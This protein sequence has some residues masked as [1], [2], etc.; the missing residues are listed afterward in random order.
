MSYLDGSAAGTLI[1]PISAGPLFRGHFFQNETQLLQSYDYVVI[2]GGIAG[3]VVANRLSE[4]NGASV[5][6]IEVGTFDH[7]EDIIEIPKKAGEAVNTNYDWKLTYIPKPDVLNRAIQLPQGKAVGGGSLLNRM[8]LGNSGWGWHGL[9]PFFKKIEAEYNITFNESVHGKNGYV[10]SSYSLFFWPSTSYFATHTQDP[11]NATRSTARTA[12]YNPFV[13]RPSLHL[14]TSRQVT[15]VIT[16]STHYGTKVTGVEFAE[17]SIAPRVRVNVGKE[18]ILAAGSIHSPQI[19]QLSGIG[20]PALLEKHSISMVANV[21][22][23][24][25]NLQDHPLL[26]VYSFDFPLSRSNYTNNK[27]LDAEA[28]QQYHS[29]HTGPY[30][31]AYGDFLVFL[32]VKNYTNQSASIHQQ[33]LEQDTTAYLEADTP[34]SVV[35]GYVAQHKLLVDGVN[36]DNQAVLELGSVRLASADPFGA[37]VADPAFLHNPLDLRLIVEAVKYTRQIVDTSAFKPFNPADKLVNVT[38]NAGFEFFVRKNITTLQHPVGTCKAGPFEKEFRVYGVGGL[39]VVDAS[40]FPSTH[41]QASV[42]AVAE[43]VGRS[44]FP[45]S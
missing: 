16:E 31:A 18:A 5:L 24:G 25:R 35:A 26:F 33:A 38:S 3:L 39:R 34:E 7:Q 9:L 13:S 15:R 1:S 29:K 14:L 8:S 45:L 4:D 6:I 23:V 44:L 41:L 28:L 17:S 37:P 40:V 43:M 36:A 32:P 19:L 42:Y 27:T 20:E 21:P 30:S 22:G 11:S 12:Y 10:R 2:G